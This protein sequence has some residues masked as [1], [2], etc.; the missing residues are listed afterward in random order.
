MSSNQPAP[1][2]KTQPHEA[3]QLTDQYRKIGPAAILGALACKMKE[4][5]GAKAEAL[6][7]RRTA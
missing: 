3:V 5:E 2:R 6:K 7:A 4:H 1:V